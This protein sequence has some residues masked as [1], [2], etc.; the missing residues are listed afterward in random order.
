M[1]PR[2]LRK[3][4]KAARQCHARILTFYLGDERVSIN[5]KQQEKHSLSA[6]YQVACA[7]MQIFSSVFLFSLFL[8]AFA[9][10]GLA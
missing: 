4:R 6:M 10:D 2:L 5:V 1:A 8:A 9:T 7:R 3:K